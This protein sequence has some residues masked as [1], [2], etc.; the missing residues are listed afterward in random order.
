MIHNKKF[1]YLFI[2]GK[3]PSLLRLRFGP[4]GVRFAGSENM[5][6]S[7]VQVVETCEL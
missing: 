6:L 2:K 5:I 4:D 1:N 7:M 3:V